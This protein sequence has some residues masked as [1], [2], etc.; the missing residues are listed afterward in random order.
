LDRLRTVLAADPRGARASWKKQTPLMWL[1]PADERLALA[2][3]KELVQHGA[4]PSVV[5]EEGQTAADR[6]E[7]MG[8]VEVAAFL[9]A[10]A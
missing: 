9:R 3:V 6:A 5:N 10:P 2:I 8:M 4:D 7:A 1:P